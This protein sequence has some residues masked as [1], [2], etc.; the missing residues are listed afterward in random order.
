MSKEQS[1]LIVVSNVVCREQQPASYPQRFWVPEGL[2]SWDTPFPEY[3]NLPFHDAPRAETSKK[4]EGDYADPFR[5]EQVDWLSRSSWCGELRF[6]KDGYPLNPLGR[7]GLEGRGILNAWG[8]TKAIDTIITRDGKVGKGNPRGEP[9]MIVITRAD[10]GKIATIGGKL[11]VNEHNEPIESVYDAFGRETYEEAGI[12][13]DFSGGQIIH[14]G[15]SDD[16]RNTDN[17]WLET[18]AIHL[19]M[20]RSDSEVFILEP[21]ED[22]VEQ[23]EWR[24]TNNETITALN[25][26][27]AQMTRAAIKRL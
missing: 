1:G 2:I 21:L 25:A 7:T 23:P 12:D 3:D 26:S 8:P 20:D 11:N 17:A 27:G 16:Q 13:I 14:K 4:K 6:G 9:E 19:H 15:Y 5:P 24:V 18:T 10:N 22:D